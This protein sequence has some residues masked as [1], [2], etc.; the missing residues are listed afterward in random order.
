M[1]LNALTVVHVVLSLIGIGSGVVAI[2][3]LLKAKTLD[4]WT[5]TGRVENEENQTQVSLRFPQPL[6]IAAR[7]PH[8][9]RSGAVC[10]SGKKQIRKPKKGAQQSASLNFTPSGSFLD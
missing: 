4:R 9:H 8:S 3:G 7:F 10:I 2:H 6:E 1:I 5:Q